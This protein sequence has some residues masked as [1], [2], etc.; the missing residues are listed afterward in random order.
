MSKPENLVT[1]SEYARIHRVHIS[2]VTRWIESGHIPV[3]EVATVRKMVPVD[4]QPPKLKPGAK[5]GS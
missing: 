4:A 1:P 2:T 5:K 3:V